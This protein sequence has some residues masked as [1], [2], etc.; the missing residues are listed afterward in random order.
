VAAADQVGLDTSSPVHP[1]LGPIS[2]E[3]ALV[4]P[5]LAAAARELLPPPGQFR[6]RSVPEPVVLEEPAA[7]VELPPVA[8]E[9]APVAVE[10]A[11][12]RRRRARRTARALVLAVAAA[13]VFALGY[14]VGD[15]TSSSS[16]D[17][18]LAAR[19][20]A[21]SE[22]SASHGSS[23]DVHGPLRR[24]SASAAPTT[25][26][27]APTTTARATT[28]TAPRPATTTKASKPPAAPPPTVRRTTTAK[29]PPTATT[30]TTRTTATKSKPPADS[31]FV[32]A[33]TW[34]WAPVAGASSYRVS[35]NR[36]AS[37]FYRATTREPRRELP[38]RIKFVPG[39]YTWSVVPIV[40]GRPTTEV[41]RSS[42]TVG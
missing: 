26:T 19:T 20:D 11:P 10:P 18:E 40:N 4:D 9:P 3:L 12:P 42:F 22:A 39:R 14:A 23:T 37:P 30:A 7:P 38:A 34:T 29:K 24:P 5:V 16:S 2:P 6:P 33:R 27:L 31:G 25:R 21:L 32:P 15:R 35:F 28:T 13:A 41:V 1:E 8:A 17:T 36:D